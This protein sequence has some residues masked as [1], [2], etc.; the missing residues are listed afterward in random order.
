M[1]HTAFL[2]PDIQSELDQLIPW[3]AELINQQPMSGAHDKWIVF[4]IQNQHMEYLLNYAHIKVVS[5]VETYS[6]L[7]FSALYV[8]SPITKMRNH[9]LLNFYSY[10]PIKHNIQEDWP[11]KQSSWIDAELSGGF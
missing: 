4:Y 8:Q 5:Y 7:S 6:Y 11:T 2:V 3:V 10:C 9:S 1:H